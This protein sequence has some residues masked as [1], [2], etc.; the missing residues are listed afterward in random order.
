V[1]DSDK[2]LDYTVSMMLPGLSPEAEAIA[3]VKASVLTV[4]GQGRSAIDTEGTVNDF[5]KPG[6]GLKPRNGWSATPKE[7]RL[8][9]VVFEYLSGNNPAQA[10]WSANLNTREVRYVNSNAKYMSWTPNY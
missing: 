2:L 4:P 7:N 5:M 10:V 9:D 6:S 1:V 3:L 8:Y